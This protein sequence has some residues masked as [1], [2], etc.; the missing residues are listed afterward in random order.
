MM[1]NIASFLSE[2]ENFPDALKKNNMLFPFVLKHMLF[3]EDKFIRDDRL[4]IPK[5]IY[6]DKMCYP[7][8]LRIHS[9]SI[10]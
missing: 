2:T 9:R 6:H 7:G 1:A 5:P 4:K 10:L 8:N 3:F